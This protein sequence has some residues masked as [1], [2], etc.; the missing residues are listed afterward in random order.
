M[1]DGIRLR[2]GRRTYTIQVA[3]PPDLKEQ[4]LGAG[5]KPVAVIERSLHTSDPREA[6]ARGAKERADI[7]AMFSDIRRGLLAAPVE[8]HAHRRDCRP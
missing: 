2:E 1:G 7:L 6:K 8:P 3:V 4:V 5:G